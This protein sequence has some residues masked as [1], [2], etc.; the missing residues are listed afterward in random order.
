LTLWL[1]YKATNSITRGK[2]TITDPIETMMKA[3]TIFLLTIANAANIRAI[4]KP[5]SHCILDISLPSSI[6]SSMRFSL[7][8]ISSV[9][10]CGIVHLHNQLYLLNKVC[11]D[12][13]TIGG[14]YYG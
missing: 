13:I 11:Q 8:R 9:L 1:L 6:F 5:A 14:D 3:I 12:K 2:S 4:P 7:H 10:L